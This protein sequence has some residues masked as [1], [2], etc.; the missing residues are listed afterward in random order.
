MKNIF[1]VSIALLPVDSPHKGAVTRTFDVSLLSVWKKIIEPILDSLVIRNAMAV[2][3][4]RRNGMRNYIPL[5]ILSVITYACFN[6]NLTMIVKGAPEWFY[7]QRIT[8]LSNDVLY[9]F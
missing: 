2:I 1:R 4:R 6:L 3:W 7:K 8:W 5:K 9:V